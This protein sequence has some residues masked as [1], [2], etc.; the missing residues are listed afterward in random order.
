MLMRRFLLILRCRLLVILILNVVRYRRMR[1]IS[2]SL[3]VFYGC[4]RRLIFVGILIS[5]LSYVLRGLV[6]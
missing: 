4:S 6:R 3:R 2:R 1:L 5:S